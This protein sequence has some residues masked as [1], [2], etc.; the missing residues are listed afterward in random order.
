[1]KA[2]HGTVVMG[3]EASASRTRATEVAPTLAGEVECSFIYT[4][5]D[6][7]CKLRIISRRVQFLHLSP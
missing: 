5:L 3:G 4:K 1:M 6:N 7:Y 2:V